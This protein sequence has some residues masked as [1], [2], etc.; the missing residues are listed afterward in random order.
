MGQYLAEKK[1]KFYR[2]DKCTFL[3]FHFFM[4]RIKVLRSDR[5]KID[6]S[7]VFQIL[8]AL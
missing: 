1:A 8:V 2:D 5:L 7:R 3:P 6:L 4:S